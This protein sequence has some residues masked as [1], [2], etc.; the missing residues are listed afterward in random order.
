MTPWPALREMLTAHDVCTV[1][2]VVSVEGSAPREVGARMIVGPD[3]RFRGTI[4]GGRLEYDAIHEAARLAREEGGERLLHRRLSLGPDLGQCCGGRIGL[5][6]E[7]FSHARHDEI[8]RLARAAEAGGFATRLTLDAHGRPG[9]RE[10]L[11]RATDAPTARLSGGVL[12]E[13]F[14]DARTPLLLFGAGHVGKALVLALAPLPF[15]VTWVDPRAEIFPPAMPAT[16]RP[17]ALADPLSALRDAPAGSE[18]VIMTHDHA[19]DLAIADRALANPAIAGVGM[20]GSSTK[21]A[22]MRARLARAGHGG[23]ALARFRSPI[24]VGGITSKEPPVIAAS[25]AADLLIRRE[26]ASAVHSNRDR[27]LA[28][29][30]GGV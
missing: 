15:R 22:R 9:P 13:T 11:P 5:V 27:A 3:A 17:C 2:T 14:G 24:G 26:A 20:I 23:D 21:A 10:I 12:T 19:L 4:G 8:A 28:G 7:T 1:V 25:V 29:A 6:F 18:V 16:V 30:F